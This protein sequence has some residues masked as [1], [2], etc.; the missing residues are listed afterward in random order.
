MANYI[1]NIIHYGVEFQKEILHTK[2]T[3]KILIILM[4]NLLQKKYKVSFQIQRD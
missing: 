4:K 3:L 1:I 2:N